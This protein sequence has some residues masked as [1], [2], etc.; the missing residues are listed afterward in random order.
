MSEGFDRLAKL[1][2]GGG[3]RR[4]VLKGLGA[5]LAG[6]F[7]VGIT[8]RARAD[9]DDDDDDDDEKIGKACHKYCKDCPRKPHGVHGKCQRQCVHFLRK[10]PKG[11]LCGTC[12]AKNPFTGCVSAATC[13]AATSTAAAFCSNLNTDVSNCGKCG[14]ACKG[15]T[16]GCCSGTCVDLASDAN[17]CGKCGNKCSS[18]QKCTKGVCG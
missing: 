13:C 8:G 17:N 12:T 1:L 4:D 2:A 6:C 18:T 5:L 14:N 7:L 10:N 15:T 16:P 9:H 3:S 11:T